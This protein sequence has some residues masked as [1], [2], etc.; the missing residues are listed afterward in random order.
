MILDKDSLSI[1]I[2][3]KEE[4]EQY[5]LRTKFNKVLNEFKKTVSYRYDK[6]FN[7]SEIHL[8]YGWIIF[9]YTFNETGN[10]LTYYANSENSLDKTIYRREE[11]NKLII[12]HYKIKKNK[13]AG[14]F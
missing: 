1:V 7:E 11:N 14:L 2:H 12:Y 9:C 6:R 8:K 3:Y 4:I 10:L 5:E 13:Y